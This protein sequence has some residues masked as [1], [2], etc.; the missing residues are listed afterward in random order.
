MTFFNYISIRSAKSI[1]QK[2]IKHYKTDGKNALFNQIIGIYSSRIF[3]ICIYRSA[4]K[5]GKDIQ[6]IETEGENYEK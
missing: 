5:M 1:R 4:N 6:Q 2:L 3:G